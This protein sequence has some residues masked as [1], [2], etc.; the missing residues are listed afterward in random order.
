MKALVL[1]YNHLSVRPNEG[2]VTRALRR[3][4]FDTHNFDSWITQELSVI[5]NDDYDYDVIL[6]PYS[7]SD[8]NYAEYS[9]LRVAAHIRLMNNALA[10]KPIV[11]VG[12]EDFKTVASLSEL[13]SILLTPYVF[14]TT[15][16]LTNSNIENW[17]E[18]NIGMAISTPMNDIQYQQFL[19]R[20]V[21]APPAKYGDRHSIANEWASLR[22]ANLL[23][24]KN[25]KMS[26]MKDMLFFKLMQARLGKE[27]KFSTSWFKNNPDIEKVHFK[28][29]KKFKIALIDDEYDKGWEDLLSYVFKESSKQEFYV[30]KDFGEGIS[31][32]QLLERICQFADNVEA[33]CYLLDLRLHEDDSKPGTNPADITGH[34]VSKYL[35]DS[36]KGNRVVVFT[37]SNKVW[38]LKTEIDEIKASGYVIKESPEQLCSRKTTK[39]GFENLVNEVRNACYQSYIKK[40]ITFIEK[41]DVHELDDFVNLLLVDKTI[42]KTTILSSLLLTLIV[43]LEKYVTDRFDFDGTK[44]IRKDGKM[45]PVEIGKRIIVEKEEMQDK[46][47]WIK[48]AEFHESPVRYHDQ[49]NGYAEPYNLKNGQR[50]D[51][52]LVIA[53][54]HYA[55][56]L[57]VKEVNLYLDGKHVRNTEVAHNGGNISLT[58]EDITELFERIIMPMVENEKL[59]LEGLSPR[60]EIS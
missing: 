56:R 60:K 9:G 10:R 59:I 23:Q 49:F 26:E 25:I 14:T 21:L 47:I 18:K 11:F 13:S 28:N 42:E 51:M 6:L 8:N 15:E 7:I 35:M 31:R 38:N 50:F 22:W 46:H 54:M 27:Q 12:P 39:M 58:I 53:A 5:F 3:T 34:K 1:G 40:Y 57:S 32:E 41:Q 2:I 19:D 44:M 45:T 48:Q 55:Y 29:N 43:F 16:R 30:F 24:R 4:S 17:C 52:T 37:A 36:N 33:D 20:F